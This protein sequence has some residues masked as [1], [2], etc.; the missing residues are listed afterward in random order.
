MM[1]SLNRG[2]QSLMERMRIC[3]WCRK[4]LDVFEHRYHQDCAWRIRALERI[5]PSMWRTGGDIL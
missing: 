4:P 3:F 1:V 5:P 2:P